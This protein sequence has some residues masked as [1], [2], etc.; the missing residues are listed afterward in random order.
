MR[1]VRSEQPMRRIL[2]ACMEGVSDLSAV[3]GWSWVAGSWMLGATGC[4][5]VL[6]RLLNR[7]IDKG[8]SCSLASSSRG[9]SEQL[10]AC[11]ERLRAGRRRLRCDQA[12]P[13]SDLGPGCS[14]THSQLP[15]LSF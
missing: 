11:L 9:Q 12:T 13:S 2:G 7:V 4:I 1:S 5:V 3:A 15:P 6:V 10:W 8:A 14:R